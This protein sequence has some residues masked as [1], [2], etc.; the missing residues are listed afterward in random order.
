MSKL[1]FTIDPDEMDKY[2]A[3]DLRNCYVDNVTKW[4]NQPESEKLS[5]AL[6]TVIEHYMAHSEYEDWYDTI[7]DL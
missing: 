4:C 2:I 1:T 5:D 3:A 6:L 7:K